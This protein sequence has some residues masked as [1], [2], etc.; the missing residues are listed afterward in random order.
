[1]AG[2]PRGPVSLSLKEKKMTSEWH[3]AR[4]GHASLLYYIR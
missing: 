1:M 2:T 3:P 4:Q